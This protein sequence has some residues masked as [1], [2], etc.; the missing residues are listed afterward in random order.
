MQVS[1]ER[2]RERIEALKQI[3]RDALGGTTRLSYSPE[4]LQGQALVR[5]YMEQ[6]GMT[7]RL[8]AVG[9]L[10]G[11]YAGANRQLSPVVTGSHLDTVPNGGAF[12]GALGIITAIECVHSW[13]LAGWQPERTVQVAAMIEEEGT[14]FAI[15]C[16]G[17]RALTGEFSPARQAEIVDG[18]GRALADLLEGMGLEREIRIVQAD[19]PRRW[20]CFLEL[21]VEQGAELEASGI[22][23][24][25]VTA[26]VGIE[27]LHVTIKGDANHAGTTR[28]DRRKDALV[29]AAA[30]IG[31][32]HEQ[33]L[34]AGGAYVATVGKLA[35]SPNAE[36]VVPGEVSLTIE[37]RSADT[38]V[39]AAARQDV[40]RVA[41]SY[42]Q[43]SGI[44]VQVT[45]H[46]QVLPVRLHDALSGLCRQAADELGAYCSMPSWAG[47]DA[48][49]FAPL[50]PT[51]MIFVPSIGGISH[52]P[53]ENSAWDAIA[54]ATEVL[55]L[56][57]QKAA[58]SEDSL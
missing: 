37:F 32:V 12:D 10:I 46:Q 54:K 23:V 35:V 48:M 2:I 44:T 24:G 42:A 49:T 4:Y 58:M 5:Q 29:A 13:H 19:D 8:D 39:M 33:A 28:M 30:L 41:D 38:A 34:A 45:N 50:I 16:F 25:I 55:N 52:S 40:L 9:N 47:H 7:V 21:H 27:R 15:T 51:A 17:S 14:R 31:Y 26:I 3:G 18:S 20:H 57:L 36:N 56:A 11:S 22:P 6:A 1:I 43:R 53:Q